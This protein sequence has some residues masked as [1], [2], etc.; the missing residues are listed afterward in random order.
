VEF[1]FFRS[2]TPAWRAVKGLPWLQLEICRRIGVHCVDEHGVPPPIYVK[3]RSFERQLQNEKDED[4]AEERPRVQG[5]AQDI[6]E[7][8]P[9]AEISSSDDVLENKSD[10]EPRGVVDTSCRWNGGGA[11]EQ[12]GDVDIS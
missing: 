10:H 1:F 6:V 11:I 5:S 7:L 3:T 8:A 12:Y 9:P 4:N 2:G